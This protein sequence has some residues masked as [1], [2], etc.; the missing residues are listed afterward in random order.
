[1][2][3]LKIIIFSFLFLA[4]EKTAYPPGLWALHEQIQVIKDKQDLLENL[5]LSEDKQL[6]GMILK[7]Q[8]QLRVFFNGKERKDYPS[9]LYVRKENTSFLYLDLVTNLDWE[10]EYTNPEITYNYTEYKLKCPLL[11]GDE[12]FHVIRIDF[13][14][15]DWEVNRTK[16]TLDGREGKIEKQD[17]QSSL[18][19]IYPL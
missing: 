2:K 4:C 6:E 14:L 9:D 16:I 18:S 5:E 13:T 19:T 3:Y 15:Q 10:Y 8:Y 17:S 7:N 12:D 11:F 1:M